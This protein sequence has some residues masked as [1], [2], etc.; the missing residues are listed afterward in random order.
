MRAVDETFK[1][2]LLLFDVI[3]H[4]KWTT[5]MRGTT[6][7]DWTSIGV[8]IYVHVCGWFFSLRNQ[9]S[10]MRLPH[11][12]YWASIFNY[13]FFSP[14]S[15]WNREKNE[16]VQYIGQ[17][18]LYHKQIPTNIDEFSHVVR[19]NLFDFVLFCFFFYYICCFVHF[20][21]CCNKMCVSMK[22]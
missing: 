6:N 15:L 18:W 2:V 7:Y 17:S 21:C 19:S 1:G 9:L 11:S 10:R 4:P 3:R 8:C 5:M 12:W 13:A 14:H 20:Y 16:F 22:W